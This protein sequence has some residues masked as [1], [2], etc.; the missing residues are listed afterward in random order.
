M[1]Y[2]KEL[3]ENESEL[4]TT[5]YSFNKDNNGEYTTS[6]RDY[7]SNKDNSKSREEFA[8]FNF[9]GTFE[10]NTNEVNS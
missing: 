9:S 1:E 2:D 10:N 6:R 8:G 4:N 7:A 3:K 5:V